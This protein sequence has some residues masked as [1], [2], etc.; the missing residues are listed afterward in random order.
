MFL[1]LSRVQVAKFLAG[2]VHFIRETDVKL[3][4]SGLL[5]LS[6]AAAGFACHAGCKASCAPGDSQ[7]KRHVRQHEVGNTE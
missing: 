1:D 5:E 6:L 3:P 7:L 2:G 4:H